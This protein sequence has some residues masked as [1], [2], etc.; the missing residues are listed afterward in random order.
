M[1]IKLTVACALTAFVV[2]AGGTAEATGLIHTNGIAKG[3]ITFDRLSLGVQKK[4]SAKPP[5][6]G[7]NGLGGINGATGAPGAL[8]AVGA[9]GLKGDAGPTGPEGV[10]GDP[11][12][13]GVAGIAGGPCPAGA[14]G[15]QGFTGDAG[16]AGVAGAL[17]TKGDA[18]ATGLQ[19]LHR[20]V[21][22]LDH[23]LHH[24]QDPVVGH[25]LAAGL[26]AGGDVD[27]LELGQDQPDGAERRLSRARMA[28][29]IASFSLFAQHDLCPD[30][31]EERKLIASGA[32]GKANK[33]L[34][35]LVN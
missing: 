3:A 15:V 6:G 10:K 5:K 2:V 16:T 1:R 28:S 33:L 29:F 32:V 26:G 8:G 9:Q 31:S 34:K 7:T 22:L 13:I 4:V 30:G 19:G 25:A 14:Q 21:P 35:K 11:G 12:L 23:A 27:F 18:G 24:R 20:L 17:G